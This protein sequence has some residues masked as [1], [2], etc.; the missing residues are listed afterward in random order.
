MKKISNRAKYNILIFSVIIL[1]FV[2]LV[3]ACFGV[4]LDACLY[5]TFGS[6]LITYE[7][8]SLYEELHKNDRKPTKEIED[9][10]H[11]ENN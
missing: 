5:F 3:H 1:Y 10:E 9:K 7:V 11:E 8:D 6:L 2:G 4:I